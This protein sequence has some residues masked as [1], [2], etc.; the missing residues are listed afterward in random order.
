MMRKIAC[1]LFLVMFAGMMQAQRMSRKDYIEKYQLLAISEMNRSGVPAS[2]KMAQ[3]CLESADGN[4]GLAKKGNNHFGIKCGSQWSGGRTYYDDDAKNEC[5]R[6][7]KN[8]EDS[9]VDH[10]NFLINNQRYAPLFK[11]KATDYAGWARELKKCGYATNP[12]YDKLLID[13]IEEHQLWRLDHKM[14]VREMV[15]FEEISQGSSF[16]KNLLINPYSARPI[17]PH[18]RMKAAV[19]RQGDTFE[20]LAQEFGKKAWEL[21]KFNDYPDGMEP[22]PDEIIYLQAKKKQARGL[23]NYHVVNNGESMHHIS[24]YYGIKLKQLYKMNQIN[25]GDPIHVGQVLQLKKKV[26]KTE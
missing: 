24:Q 19:T 8:V 15:Q 20:I 10:T 5:F 1:L 13:I 22:K 4:S 14:T 6:K 12:Q 9:Y 25:V 17:I 16:N 26:S 7:Y 18:N 2:I 21:R 23:Y 11:L 3:A